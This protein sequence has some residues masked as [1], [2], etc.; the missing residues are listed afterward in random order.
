MNMIFKSKYSQMFYKVSVL[1]NF[2]KFTQ[3]HFRP[4]T[5]L[6]RDSGAGAF[7]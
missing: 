1:K 5:L 3:K 4:I 2:A 6:K 7:L